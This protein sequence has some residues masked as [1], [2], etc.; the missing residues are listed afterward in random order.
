MDE[1]TEG[2]LRQYA[3][4]VAGAS[5]YGHPIAEFSRDELLGVI[6]FLIEEKET[7]ENRAGEYLDLFAATPK[8]Q[9]PLGILAE[10]LF[11]L[12]SHRGG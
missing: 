7:W 2:I 9:T 4:R 6:G 11:G 8:P 12:R 1:H 5:I 10:K 3:T